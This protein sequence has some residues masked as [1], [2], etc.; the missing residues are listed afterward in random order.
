MHY[1]DQRLGLILL[2][3]VTAA[4]WGPYPLLGQTSPS[5][6]SYTPPTAV[7]RILDYDGEIT[8][9]TA[10]VAATVEARFKVLGMNEC[11]V[12][13]RGFYDGTVPD[14]NPGGGTLAPGIWS[15]WDPVAEHT[16]ATT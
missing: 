13:I 2:T 14:Q 6:A 11:S 8:I 15:P 1:L 9:Q 10:E 16:R 5:I 12:E 7:Q 4:A 3:A